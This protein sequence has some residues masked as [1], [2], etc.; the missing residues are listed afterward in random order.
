MTPPRLH[1]RD[2]QLFERSTQLRIPFKFGAN[3]LAEAPQV[4]VRLEIE[5]DGQRAV[6][7]SAEL[8]APK[9]FD[10]N[11]DLDNEQNFDQ[12]R[13]SLGSAAALYRTHGRAETAFALHAAVLSQHYRN[14]AANGLNG[15]IASY[16]LALIDRAVLDALCHL[17]SI[18]IFEAIRIN[19]PGIT[20]ELT[21]DLSQGELDAWLAGRAS[22]QMI[23][24]RH[25][26]GMSD[27]LTDA[28]IVSPLNDGYPQSLQAVIAAYGNRFFKLKVGSDTDASIDRLSAIAAVLDRQEA[29]Y[30]VTLDGNEQL[31]DVDAVAHLVD[32]I[33]TTPRLARLWDSMLFVEQP[34]ARD[35][36]L[37]RSVAAIAAQI[38]LVLDESDSDLS[39][40]PRGREL[41]YGGV[42][43]KTCKGV[44]RALL[45]AARAAA[46][47]RGSEG[48]K[49]FVTAE[50]LTVQ[51]GVALQQSLALACLVGADHVELNGHHYVGGFGTVSEQEQQR[52]AGAHPDIY[53]LQDRR[54]RLRID[55][56]QVSIASL[57]APGFAVA[58]EPDWGS[59]RPLQ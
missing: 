22:P 57:G 4:F 29:A 30:H 58:V 1:I 12:L 20:T 52:F 50:D 18:S 43:A 38:P 9:W 3:T 5:Q 56:G 16:G 46:W 40:F 26:V 47:N 13:S 45:N 49:H 10:K 44:Y 8:L 51:A 41:G 55:N 15:L 31:A 21:P 2:I 7:L 28:D 23:N 37:D 42:S 39:I 17:R 32:R 53:S 48:R 14:C 19:L 35:K 6:G 36:A 25:T 27:P 33:R 24:A 59:L 34:L 11:P 54:A